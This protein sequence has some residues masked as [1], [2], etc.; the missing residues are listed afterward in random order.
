MV[1]AQCAYLLWRS[2]RRLT[3]V[4]SGAA[5]AAADDDDDAAAAAI[6]HSHP[7][8]YLKQLNSIWL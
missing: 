1:T 6:E 5:A 7:A 4:S 8:L 3:V 2:G